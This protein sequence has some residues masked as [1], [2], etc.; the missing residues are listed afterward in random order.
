MLINPLQLSLRLG[1]SWLL[2]VALSAQA[3]LVTG[4]DNSYKQYPGAIWRVR[5]QPRS[6]GLFGLNTP[7]QVHLS[8]HGKPQRASASR[9]KAITEVSAL[10]V[11]HHKH[12]QEAHPCQLGLVTKALAQLP[13]PLAT[14]QCWVMSTVPWVHNTALRY[15]FS[16][17]KCSRSK[18]R[19]DIMQPKLP[20]LLPDS[21]HHFKSW[22]LEKIQ[23]L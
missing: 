9:L 12:P 14:E 21:I 5:S 23:G 20:D 17:P 22:A 6:S 8:L 11:F 18:D 10:D 7:G 15:H 19:T 3:W 4:L 2:P 1:I 13:V 16:W